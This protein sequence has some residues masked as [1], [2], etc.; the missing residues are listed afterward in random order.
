MDLREIAKEVTESVLGKNQI[1]V[2]LAV[3]HYSGRT[4]RITSGQFWG[5]SG[6]ISNHWHWREIMPDGSLSETEEACYGYDL[7]LDGKQYEGL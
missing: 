2:G 5:S 3:R 6:G 1:E 4:V 7:I